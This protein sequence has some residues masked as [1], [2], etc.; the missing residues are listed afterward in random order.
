MGRIFEVRKA[1]MFA[2]WDKMAKQFSRIGKDIAI[3]VKAGG[4]DPSI[5]SRAATLHAECQQREYAQGQGG[6]RYQTRIRERNGAISKSC[7]TKDMHRMAWPSWL[8]LPPITLL[9]PLPTC[10][11]I[12][13]KDMALL[14]TAEA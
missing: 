3:A 9:A 8:K 6:S 14:E 5:Q 4:P 2:R 1:T 13:I 10:A 7:F 12:S 11:R